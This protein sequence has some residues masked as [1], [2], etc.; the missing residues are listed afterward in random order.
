MCVF[1]PYISNHTFKVGICLNIYYIYIYIYIYTYIAEKKKVSRS[2]CR[3]FTCTLNF[4]RE[5]SKLH[6]CIYFYLF[7]SYFLKL[8]YFH[9]LSYFFILIRRVLHN[10]SFTAY[11]WLLY[12]IQLFYIFYRYYE[13]SRQRKIRSLGFGWFN[14]AK[15]TKVKK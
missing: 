4:K 7:F 13:H 9:L 3:I 12:M 14:M 8:S 6:F 11:N 15:F 2:L 10:F 5:K 1:L